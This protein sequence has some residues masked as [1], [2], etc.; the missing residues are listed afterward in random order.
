ML[1]GNLYEI[2]FI[3]MVIIGAFVR[4]FLHT[5]IYNSF[6]RKYCCMTWKPSDQID[7]THEFDVPTFCG[8]KNDEK[9]DRSSFW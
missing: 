5:I 1:G 4:C 2:S 7:S 3:D 9:S 8:G 6:T